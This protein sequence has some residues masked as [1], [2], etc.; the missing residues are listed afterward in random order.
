MSFVTT[1]KFIVLL[2]GEKNVISNNRHIF[3]RKLHF[4]VFANP[5]NISKLDGL[6][7]CFFRNR[8]NSYISQF[9]MSNWYY[10]CTFFIIKFM[11][12]NQMI[13]RT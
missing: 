4:H 9:H 13:N 12:H 6:R 2:E 8:C 1:S 3:F 7:D 5:F 10:E 11:M